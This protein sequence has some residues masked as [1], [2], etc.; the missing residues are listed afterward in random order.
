MAAMSF[1]LAKQMFFEG[2][3]VHG[4]GAW[5]SKPLEEKSFEV[6]EGLRKNGASL[7]V[8]YGSNRNGAALEQGGVE[9]CIVKWVYNYVEEEKKHQPGPDVKGERKGQSNYV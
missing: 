5:I 3:G 7:P 9:Q 8:G 6:L 2:L 4:Y 1:Q